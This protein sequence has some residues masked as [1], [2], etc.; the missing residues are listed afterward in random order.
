MKDTK[1]FMMY[2]SVFAKTLSIDFPIGH[3]FYWVEKIIIQVYPEGTLVNSAFLKEIVNSDIV[4]TM[5]VY[6]KFYFQL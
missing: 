3:S 6:E 2:I 4:F 5:V 1:N